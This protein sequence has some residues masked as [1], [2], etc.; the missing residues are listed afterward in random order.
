PTPYPPVP[1]LE[2]IGY[3]RPALGVGGDYYDFV[4]VGHGALGIVVGD[5]SGKGIPAALL[6]AS[7][8]A[9]VHAQAIAE[10]PDL[11]TLMK[12][13]NALIYEASPGNRYAT[14]FYGQYDPVT[15]YL[16]Y[17]NA[18]HN[19]PLVFRPR[20]GGVEVLKV[21]GGGTVIGLLPDAEYTECGLELAPGDLF[22]GYTDGVSEAM[23][24]EDEEWGEERMIQA[25]RACLN[26]HPRAVVPQVM[27]AADA[28]ASGARQN[29]DM[30]LGVVRAVGP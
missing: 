9:S 15:R 1:G 18:G 26:L 21:E 5:I 3:C 28:L 14:F 24:T 23:N 20:D 7:L 12:R 29:A 8:R 25:I 13:L 17:V 27:S 30:T 10:P 4:R 11:G 19:P 16:A 6:M 22:V 2:Y